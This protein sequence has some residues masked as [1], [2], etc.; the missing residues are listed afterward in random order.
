MATF[1]TPVSQG[2]DVP[3]MHLIAPENANCNEAMGE[4]REDK[5][6]PIVTHRIGIWNLRCW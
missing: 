5:K 6:L 2:N 4:E 3:E 1:G